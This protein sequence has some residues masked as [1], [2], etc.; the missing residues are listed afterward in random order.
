MGLQ[1]RDEVFTAHLCLQNRVKWVGHAVSQ[2]IHQIAKRLDQPADGQL[3][4]IAAASTRALQ[5]RIS[6]A[7]LA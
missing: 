3:L 6:S 1:K 7:V 4:K 2:P 5:N